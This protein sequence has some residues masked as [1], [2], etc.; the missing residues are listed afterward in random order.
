MSKENKKRKYLL[1]SSA[2]IAIGSTIYYLQTPSGKN[3]LEKVRTYKDKTVNG[4]KFVKDHRHEI[5]ENIKDVSGELSS[6]FASI[7]EEV[8]KIA[9]SAIKVK[10]NTESIMKKTS[11]SIDEIRQLKDEMKMS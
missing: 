6:N 4:L 8:S 9:D 3:V 7:A 10:E 5:Y 1:F 2:L 11:Q